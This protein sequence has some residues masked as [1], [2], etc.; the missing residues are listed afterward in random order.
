MARNLIRAGHEVAVW[1]NTSAK[2]QKL[3]DAEKG[4][5]CGTP[6]EVAENAFLTTDDDL[7]RRAAGDIATSFRCA[8]RT[9]Y[10]GIGRWRDDPP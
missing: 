5:V 4:K 3:A 10:P 9:R 6:K 1:S 8:S 7:L 2:A